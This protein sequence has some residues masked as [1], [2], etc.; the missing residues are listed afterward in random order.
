MISR[1]RRSMLFSG[2]M[3]RSLKRLIESRVSTHLISLDKLETV[4]LEKKMREKV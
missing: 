2:I 4:N 1:R 3:M